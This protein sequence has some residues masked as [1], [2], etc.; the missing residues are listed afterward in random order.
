MFND[1]HLFSYILENYVHVLCIQRQSG[2]TEPF[3]KVLR[4]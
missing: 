3:I 1:M 4:R 2:D